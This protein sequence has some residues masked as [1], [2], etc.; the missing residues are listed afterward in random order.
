MTRQNIFFGSLLFILSL[1]T[2]SCGKGVV[3]NLDMEQVRF[4]EFITPLV[5]DG[6]PTYERPAPDYSKPA[7][8]AHE[9]NRTI[10][11]VIKKDG[12]TPGSAARNYAYANVAAYEAVRP[13]Y[14]TWQSMAGQ[15][16]GLTTPPQ[17]TKGQDY[18][19]RVAMISAYQH[20]LP[21]LIYRRVMTDSA[22]DVYYSVISNS[23]VSSEVMARSKEYGKQV[24][25]HIIAWMNN[26]NFIQIGAKSRYIVEKYPGAWVRTPPGFSDPVDPYWN[27]HRTF[28][29]D[30]VNQFLPPAPPNFSADPESDFYNMVNVVYE[31]DKT[32]TENQ[33]LIAQFWD[34]NPIHSNHDGHFVWNTR[35]VS[36]GGHWIS[37]AG[38]AAEKEGYSLMESLGMYVQVSVA[39]ADGF[40]SAWDAKYRY[41]LVRPVTYIHQYIDSTWEP[42]IETPP[43]PE[44]TSAH[45]TISAASAAVL[46]HLFGDNY[47]FD[48]W[49]EAY[50]GL[51]VRRQKSFKDAALEVT[52]SRIWG[53]IHYHEAC[54]YGT[55]EGWKLGEYVIA[56]LKTKK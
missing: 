40:I 47:E 32:A 17:P 4:G 27:E 55:N 51:P 49:T 42:H 41:N 20:S 18:D 3:K 44:W 28:V 48:D 29:L 21:Q 54:Q 11:E 16:N 12:F 35:Q 26:D 56:N 6:T 1:L 13:A 7:T 5:N 24:A 36:P 9:M 52:W 14:P 45:S 2:L 43:F 50:L 8:F 25:E 19:W 53:G 33:K 38:I 30:S 31:V 39:L 22:A 46:T 34:C 15:L 37:I 10:I 23:G